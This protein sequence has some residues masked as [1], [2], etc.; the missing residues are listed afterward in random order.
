MAVRS[1][2]I[3]FNKDMLGNLFDYLMAFGEKYYHRL[4]KREKRWLSYWWVLGLV[5]VPG[6]WFAPMLF[7]GKLPIPL[8]GLL[9]SY[10]PWLDKKW[11]FEVGVPVQNISVT[12]VFSQ[13][14]PWRLWSMAMWRMGEVPLWNPFSF[15]GTPHLANWQS[16]AFYPLNVLMLMFGDY[17]GWSVMLFVQPVLS[18]LGMWW[19]LQG[20]KVSRLGSLVGATVFSL[21]GFMMTYMEYGTTGQILM[22]LP[23]MLGMWDR[24][25][26]SE[27][28]TWIIGIGLM[29]F[30]VLTG[31]FF[32]PALYVLLMLGSYI[33][34]RM[35]SLRMGWRLWFQI[36]L[37]MGLGVATAGVQLLPTWELL[38]LSI[39]ELDGNIEGYGYG[40]L[41]WWHGVMLFA[42]DFLGNPATMNWRG[43]I[44]YQ[45]TSGYFSI[46]SWILVL[47]SMKRIRSGWVRFWLIWLVVSLVL[48]FRNPASEL[49]Y[50]MG[51]P[52]L[53]TGYAA[54][55]LMV[56]STAGAMLAALGLDQLQDMN[57]KQSWS[58]VLVGA[59]L[60]T[61]VVIGVG[62]EVD[63]EWKSL[64]GIRALQSNVDVWV[65]VRNSVLSGGLVGLVVLCWWL[66]PRKKFLSVMF[67]VFISFDLFRFAVKFT[68]FVG[69]DLWWVNEVAVVDFLQQQTMEGYFRF[70]AENGPVIPAN[71]WMYAQLRSPS[72]YDPLVYLPYAYWYRV[73]N[74]PPDAVRDDTRVTGGNVSRY[75]NWSNYQSDFIDLA[76]VKYV[77]GA[78]RN[79]ESKFSAE[80]DLYNPGL[81]VDD[82]QQA[83]RDGATVV[84]ENPD[85]LPRARWYGAFEV[86]ENYEDA[87]NR[88][89]SGLN[90]RETVILSEVPDLE[91][92]MGDGE[93]AWEAYTGN[94]VR[95][96]TS[97]EASG[98]LM[99]SDT[100]YPGWK[101]FV[102]GEQRNL[103]TA[104]GI[105]R[106]VAIEAGEHVV[107]M[108]YEPASF[109]RGLAVS[110][111]G[112][113]GLLGL[114][115]L[116][117][118]R[119]L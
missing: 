80:G 34:W 63:W 85:V 25:E 17:W 60:V 14:F 67:F 10:Y 29:C 97:R 31:G 68:P 3:W 20:R 22:W 91:I 50:S 114:G 40:L 19:Y 30:P 43:V 98:I 90:F 94:T 75:L 72:G 39:R 12:D 116:S 109:Q 86:E 106:A 113:I 74:L 35:V 13:L 108:R 112:V 15:S 53:S 69:E 9:G 100:M 11:G 44:G 57:W 79:K 107:E 111:L 76:G 88:L 42:P 73:Y 59:I 77:I 32:Q 101:V 81:P 66:V 8:D 21:S 65:S 45:E 7:E 61:L 62:R 5:V 18:M 82:W 33:G 1:N 47:L 46:L 38:G 58:G 37:I 4:P 87:L 103:L 78:A 64:S 36:V 117:L 56:T 71:S 24:F 104:F 28:L 115:M 99:V 95:L 52:L 2:E 92:G 54:R 41:P 23:W 118:K 89:A 96:R 51:L 83:Y 70:D 105:Y 110:F 84:W 49:V 26:R 16:G 93:V 55:W 102:D 119:K 27:Q 48:V 6:V